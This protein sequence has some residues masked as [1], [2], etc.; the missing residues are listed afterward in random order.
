M[1]KAIDDLDSLA[2]DLLLFFPT[3]EIHFIKFAVL[4]ATFSVVLKEVEGQHIY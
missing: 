4:V 3:E 2:D 1:D